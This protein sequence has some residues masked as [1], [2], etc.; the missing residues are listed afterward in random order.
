M[1]YGESPTLYIGLNFVYIGRALRNYISY[2]VAVDLI[3]F[4]D[5]PAGFGRAREYNRRV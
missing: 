4:A 2:V 3:S 1:A 5:V